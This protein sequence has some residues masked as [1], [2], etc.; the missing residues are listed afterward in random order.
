VAQADRVAGAVRDLAEEVEFLVVEVGQVLEVVRGFQEEIFGIRVLG[1]V[2]G[3]VLVLGL[4]Q[5]LVRTV[6]KALREVLA[7]VWQKI[8]LAHFPR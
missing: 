6:D 3:R 8:R 5:G 7:P 4:G 2:R 1:R